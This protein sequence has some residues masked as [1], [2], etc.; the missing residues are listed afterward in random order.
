MC[1][2][3]GFAPGKFREIKLRFNIAGDLPLFTPRYNIAPSQ[4]APVIANVDGVNLVEM[5]RWGLVPSWAKDPSIGNRM[6]NA[7]AETLA[8]KPSFKRLIKNR[9]CLVLAD[10]FYEWRKEGKGKVP[11]WFKL[12]TNEPFVFAGLWDAWR[13]PDGGLLRTHSIITTEPNEVLAP[14]HNRMPVMLSDRDAL[15]WVGAD[16]GEI[17]HALSLLKPY[18]AALM[19][20]YDVSKLVNNP[21]NDLPECIAPIDA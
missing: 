21:L 15:E 1:G 20:G 10:G 18:P 4:P 8:E 16:G 3:Y 14:I 5:F 2:R 11:M 12:K 19:D 6:I 17:D 7:R 13:Q 9:R